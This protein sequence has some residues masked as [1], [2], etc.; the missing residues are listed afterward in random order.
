MDQQQNVNPGYQDDEITLKELI[1]KILEVLARVMGQEMVDYTI[2]DTL[3]GL[4]WI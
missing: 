3:Y 1:E 4:F 2:Y